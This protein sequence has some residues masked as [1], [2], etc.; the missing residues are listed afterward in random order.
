MTGLPPLV[1][2]SGSPRRLQLLDQVGIR[3]ARVAALAIDESP[4]KGELP[5]Q[6]AARLAR[7]KASAASAGE[8]AFVLGADTV[9]SVGRRI[10]PKAET[11]E[12][13]RACLKLLSGRAHRVHT[14]VCLLTPKGAM[15]ERLVDTRVT[16]KRLSPDEQEGY[17]ASGEWRGKAGGYAIQGLAGAFVVQLSGSYSNVV[18]LP[19]YETVSLLVGE[20][21]PVHRGW[22]VGG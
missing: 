5:R 1:L 3:P 13:V 22:S 9:V 16:F 2:A 17:I 18:G 10:L 7:E 8:P 4:A 15:R 14:A 19:L 12:E 20:G 6:L 21:Y 11:E